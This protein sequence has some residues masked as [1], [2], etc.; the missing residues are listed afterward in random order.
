MRYYSLK[1]K[2]LI[3]VSVLVICSGLLISLMVSQ[4]YSNSLLEAAAA[5]VENI[6]HSIVL[7]A[8]DKIL[9][10]DMVALQKMLD[11]HIRSNPTISY[12]FIAK[13]G[14][15]LAHTFSKGIPAALINVNQ[16]KGSDQF[17]L[18]EISSTE[19]D[20]YLDIAWPIFAGK[21]GVLRLGFSEEPYRQA[22]TKLWIQMIGITLVIL[23]LSIT[24]TL[25]F[26]RRITRPLVE[27]AEATSRI[28]EGEMGVRVK[29][30]G[31]DEVGKLANSF[32]QMVARMEDYTHKLEKQTVE[33]ERANHQARISCD[34][35]KELGALRTLH[36]IGVHLIINFK[37]I[38]RC[39]RMMLLIFNETREMLF[40]L[41]E[42]KTSTFTEPE[43]I[44][45]T[46]AALEGRTKLTFMQNSLFQPPLI[47]ADFQGAG[48]GQA[49]ITFSGGDQPFGAL[50]IAC[51]ANCNCSKDE[52]AIVDLILSQSAGS[53]RRAITQ[54]EEL[55]NLQSRIDKAAG[56]AGIIGKD[57]RM[58]LVFK[59]I[60][61]IAPTDATV[62][63]QGESGTGKELV[64]KA[65]HELSPRKNKP[66]VVVNCS[67]YPATL[68]ESE[69]FGHEKGAFT[70]AIRQK[71]GR[72][73]QAHGGT[74]FL[75]EIG[76]IPPSAQI[77]L[78]RIL[79]TKNFERLGGE[80]TIS[81]DAR[82]IAATNK[83]LEQE[84]KRGQFRE[85]LYYR[86]N[87]IPV[88][89]PSLRERGN[90]TILL[91]RHFL[92]R[93][94]AEQG[95]KIE[96]FSA[97]AIR[98]LLSYPWPGNVRELENTIEHATVLAK[99]KRIETSDLP[100]P[101]LQNRGLLTGSSRLPNMV[102]Q[103]KRLLEETLE[104][105]GWNKKVAAERLGISRTT[106]YTKL[107]KYQ[108]QR[109]TTH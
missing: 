97:E 96:E 22:L 92:S 16:V 65:I 101:I 14:E 56:F 51:D 48:G 87:V 31:Q 35:V 75:D 107:K 80:K 8:T 7:E 5:Q 41:R 15:I 108:I 109:P 38:L 44:K 70:G 32:N 59:L 102:E 72:F 18:K 66:F 17:R 49:V 34:I 43:I 29:A 9:I 6:A 73:E 63:I 90:D 93:F 82:I 4:R 64:A 3:A 86:L 103:E 30:K 46:L 52:F 67:A 61:D 78:L 21:A 94:A 58:Q 106:L 79:Q 68:L 10:N 57:S 76:E 77:K 89:L 27:L 25:I 74:L 12:L 91:A 84:V 1:N 95:K 24:I 69:L 42:R 45:N 98:L 53:I 11:H 37:S 88:F 55:G 60:E 39:E 54:E 105:C 100:A 19:G 20:K 62:M 33:L 81:V 99:G 28:D 71:T 104:E 13:D 50:I 23:F 40:A 26:V 36:E 2:L 83:D 47:P 85:D